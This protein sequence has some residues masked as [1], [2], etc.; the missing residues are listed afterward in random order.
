MSH[1]DKNLGLL[2][3]NL[4]SVTSHPRGSFVTIIKIPYSYNLQK[5]ECCDNRVHSASE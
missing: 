3:M 5:E 4:T 1:C 2:A